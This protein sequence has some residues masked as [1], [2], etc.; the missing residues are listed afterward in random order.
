MKF[1]MKFNI[2][3]NIKFNTY[4]RFTEYCTPTNALNVYNILIF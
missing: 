4:K 1:N 2:K 3:F